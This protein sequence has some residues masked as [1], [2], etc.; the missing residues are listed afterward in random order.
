MFHDHSS[1]P[2][3]VSKVNLNPFFHLKYIDETFVHYLLNSQAGLISI[4]SGK[5]LHRLSKPRKVL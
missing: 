5:Y 2:P 3:A 4:L 1:H